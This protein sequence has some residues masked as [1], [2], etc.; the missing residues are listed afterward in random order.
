MDTYLQLPGSTTDDLSSDALWI[1]LYTFLRLYVR[2]LVYTSGIA[3]WRGQ[4][5]DIVDDIVQE[6]IVRVLKCIRR[7]ESGEGIP[8]ASPEGL[9]IVIARNYYEDLRRR[10]RR[11]VRIA[12]DDDSPGVHV[13]LQSHLDPSEMALN[14]MFLEWLYIKFSL[15]AVKF[16]HKQRTALL[17]DLA[18]RMDFEVQPTPLQKAFL[19]AG[20]RL[21]DY[22]QPLPKDAVERSRHA[23]NVSL[24]FARTREWARK[25]IH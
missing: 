18:N 24:A 22:Q 11:L 3:T 6:A 16:S 2:R 9:S 17:I 12:N 21:Q 20:I 7:A 5:D 19:E 23:S 15:A 25:N 13:V 4:E 10:D 1:N 14:N 8:V